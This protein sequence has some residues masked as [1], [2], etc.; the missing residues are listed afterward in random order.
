[1]AL[2]GRDPGELVYESR[3]WRHLSQADLAQLAGTSQSAVSLIESGQVSPTVATLVRLLD[4]AGVDLIVKVEDGAPGPALFVE[5]FDGRD[6]L[7]NRVRRVLIEQ[8]FGLFYDKVN[9][10]LPQ[11]WNRRLYVTDAWN[12]EDTPRLAAILRRRLGSSRRA[13]DSDVIEI[14]SVDETLL[15]TVSVALKPTQR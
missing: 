4:A 14:Y 8:G 9:E 2:Q 15:R 5:T 7:F 11:G 12:P 1:M 6:R 13:T 10:E 3:A